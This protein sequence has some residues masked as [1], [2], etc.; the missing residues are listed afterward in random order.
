[1]LVQ[2]IFVFFSVFF[3]VYVYEMSKE[4]NFVLIYTVFNVVM[5]MIIELV[6]YKFAND[7]VL[8][9]LFKLSFLLSLVSILLTFTIS[10]NTLYM[11]FVTQFFYA[12][13]TNFYYIPNEIATLD[14]N[15]KSQMRKFIGIN[16]I[17]SLFAKVLS[18]FLSGFII[19][20]VSYEP[21]FTIN[22]DTKEKEY[23]NQRYFLVEVK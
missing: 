4:I 17:L 3:S 10:P 18:P 8:R 15:S 6:V 21:A 11:V 7:K 1:M 5:S 14:K 16:S 19:D 22:E 12:I 13:A 9:I 2:I 20:Y 23:L